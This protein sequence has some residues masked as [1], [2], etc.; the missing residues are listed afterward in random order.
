VNGDGAW[1]AH[2]CRPQLASAEAAETCAVCH[3]AGSIADIRVTHGLIDAPFAPEREVVDVTITGVTINAGA[4]A[5]S[6]TM[7]QD[8][9]DPYADLGASS[10]RF[11]FAQ[12]TESTAGNSSFWQ[13]YINKTEDPAGAPQ[14]T[15]SDGSTEVHATYQR[16]SEGTFTNFGDGT[17]DYVFDLDVTAVTTPVAVAYDATKTHRISM[18]FGGV[19]VPNNPTYTWQPS[20]GATTGIPMRDIVRTETCNGCHEQL[21]FHGGGRKDVAYCVTCHNPG[22]VDA[23][24][25]NSV[26]FQEMVHKI[27]M[28]RDL[29]SVAAGGAYTIWGYRNRPH[30]YSEVGFPQPNTNCTLCHAAGADADNWQTRPSIEACGSCH[31]DISFAATPP[32]GMTGHTAGA[33]ANNA[34]CAGCHP[35]GTTGLAP[36]GSSHQNLGISLA[37]N[38]QYNILDVSLDSGSSVLTIDFNVTDPTNA[39][40]PYDIL[41]DTEFTTGGGVSRLAILVGWDAKDY[42]N[43]GAGSRG[44]P[45]SLNP[46]SAGV[47]TDVNGDASRFRVQA[48]LPAEATGTGVVAIE[49][50]PAGQDGD[51]NYTVRV[52]VTA[53]L[54]YFAITDTSAT[55]RRTRVDA[56]KCNNCHGVLSVHGA[57]RNNDAQLCVI[58][59]NPNATDVNRRPDDHTAMGA[60]TDG[61]KEQSVDMK[62]MIHAIHGAAKRRAPYVAFGYGNREHVFEAEEVTFPGIL[63]RC[64]ACHSDEGALALPMAEGVLGTTIDTDPAALTKAAATSTATA[65]P[66]DDI[67]VSPTAAVCSSCHDDGLTKAHMEANGASFEV[68]QS[69]IRDVR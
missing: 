22:T 66:S 69:N 21:A 12:L 36:I 61:L 62:V 20:T 50:H 48:T 44:Q 9:T 52:A 25:D 3:A 34:A 38:F 43:L 29:P 53:G 30:D 7:V 17:Y 10:V 6:F 68:L 39:D 67:N 27:H 49:G 65:D 18:Q 58:C 45:I 15:G 32:A 37:E 23:N 5:V 19:P 14:G 51:G 11:T 60:T 56:A 13:S 42:T 64:T 57:N 2:D 46:L 8:G 16:G 41:S 59:H 24:S 35:A 31:D 28:G 47:A 54:E 55:P 4:V 40:A 1:D 26:D 63:N 33:Q